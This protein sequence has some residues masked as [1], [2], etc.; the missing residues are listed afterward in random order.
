MFNSP[1]AVMK[2]ARVTLADLIKSNPSTIFDSFVTKGTSKSDKELFP[3]F[4]SR[5]GMRKFTDKISFQDQIMKYMEVINET[6]YNGF[7]IGFDTMSDSQETMGQL[8]KTYCMG[9]ADDYL[10]EKDMNLNAVLS[11][12]GNWIDGSAFFVTSRSNFDTGS[13]TINN[14]QT[15]TLSSAYTY[16]TLTNDFTLAINAM[17]AMKDRTNKPMNPDLSDLTAII[18]TQMR[19]IFDYTFGDKMQLVYSSGTINNQYAGR[20][21]IVLNPFQATTD[22]DWYLVNNKATFKPF[23]L[24]DREGVTWDQED[25]KIT[26]Q[27]RFS[28]TVRYGAK[29]LNPFCIQKINN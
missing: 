28:F 8:V 25:D 11:A 12:N 4:L 24:Q 3:V 27:H 16:A 26:R 19:E 5:Q 10:V 2:G 22:N 21:K 6:W 7:E 17:A 1:I 13:N 20:V 14:L 29:L 18:P 9:L 15:G 23:Y